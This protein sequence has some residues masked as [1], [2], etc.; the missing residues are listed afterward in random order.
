M[1]DERDDAAV[2]VEPVIL[3]ITLV[4][5]RDGDAGVQ[6]RQLAQA[7]R[8]RVEAEVDDLEDLGVRLEGDLRATLLGRAGDEQVALRSAALV[9]L[10]IDLIVSPDLEL[11]PFGSAFTTEMPTPCR[12]PETL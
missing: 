8:Q 2:V 12:P 11:E 7:L 5:Q 6:E 3:S 9:G 10:L 1:L 4:V